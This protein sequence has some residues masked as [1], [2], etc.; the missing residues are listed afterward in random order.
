MQWHTLK[1]FFEFLELRAHLKFVYQHIKQSLT[2]VGKITLVLK[3]AYGFEIVKSVLVKKSY[4]VKLL[5]L[6]DVESPCIIN[7]SIEK[8]LYV[9]LFNAFNTCYTCLYLSL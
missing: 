1:I 7:A 5:F 3:F 9:T 8:Q 6:I 2:I 4:F